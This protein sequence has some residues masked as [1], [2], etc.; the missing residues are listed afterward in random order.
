MSKPEKIVVGNDGSDYSIAAVKLAA[1]IAKALGA[2]LDVVHVS[3][4]PVTFYAAAFETPIDLQAQM[5]AL[6]AEAETRAK[7][8]L[9]EVGIDGN[10]VTLDG[11]PADALVEY[12]ENEKA[13][14]LVVGS[15]GAG[16]IERFLLGSVSNRVVHHAHCPVLVVR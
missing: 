10:L 4:L 14:L 6:K 13:G 12:A 11:N 15:R 7:T 3:H 1:E 9:A 2:T 8:A 16:A 5:D